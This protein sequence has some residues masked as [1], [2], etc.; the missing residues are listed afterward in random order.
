LRLTTFTDYALRVLIY[1]GAQ[2]ERR[3]TVAEVANAFGISQSHVSKV[4]HFLGAAGWLQNTRGHH[5]GMRL[6]VPASQV[7]IGEVV[8]LAEG[9]DVPA[10]CFEKA[11]AGEC[12]IVGGCRLKGVLAEAVQAFHASLGKHTLEDLVEPR[13][14]LVRLLFNPAGHRGADARGSASTAR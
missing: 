3:A 13:E 5:G 2:P 6:A 4:A 14:A 10:E 7:N 11:K 1:L 8:R 9:A 12:R